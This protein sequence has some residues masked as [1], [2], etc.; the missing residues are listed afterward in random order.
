[1]RNISLFAL[2][3]LLIVGCV[4]Q[5]ESIYLQDAKKEWGEKSF[6]N[7]KTENTIQVFD[8][9]YIQVSSFDDGN[10]NFMS[11]DPNRYG[12]GRSEAD[13]AMVSYTVNKNGEVKL[14][15]VG[16][17]NVLGLTTNQAAEKIRKEL[18]DYLNTP[19]VK[20]TFVNKSVTVLGS[21]NRPGR[22]FYAAEYLNIF[23]ALG[24]AGDISEYGNRKEVV[25]VRDVNNEVIRKRI[26]LTELALLGESELYIQADDVLYVEPLK[27]RQWG[28]QAFPWS[29][30]LSS[31]TTIILVANYV[32]K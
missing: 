3:M 20:V 13:L 2:A 24:L 29:I 10:I 14:P 9:I 27:K 32:E 21:V 25:I 12:G 19:S 31:I 22:Y 6:T 1:M 7:I 30:L 15:I 5:K 18:E 17:T 28:F 23:Q 16:E 26:N 4:S 8:Q 11:N